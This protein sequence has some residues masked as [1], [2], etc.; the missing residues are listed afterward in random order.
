MKFICRCTGEEF[1]TLSALERHA[2]LNHKG[3]GGF[4]L[5]IKGESE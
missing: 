1:P 3:R 2:E 5:V 4:I